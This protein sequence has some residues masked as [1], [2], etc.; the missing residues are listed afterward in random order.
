MLK[1]IKINKLTG[2]N[3]ELF[4]DLCVNFELMQI[5]PKKASMKNHKNLQ[6]QNLQLT[7][8]Y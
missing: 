8:C 2:V 3:N 1:E 5:P 4:Y 7:H 6:N